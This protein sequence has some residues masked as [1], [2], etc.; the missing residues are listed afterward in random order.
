MPREAE[1]SPLRDIHKAFKGCFE[2]PT[3]DVCQVLLLMR[4]AAFML[5]AVVSY[6]VHGMAKSCGHAVVA[7]NRRHRPRLLFGLAATRPDEAVRDS[8]VQC[9]RGAVPVRS[10][11]KS[12]GARPVQSRKSTFTPGF[13]MLASSS[14]SQLVSLT[15]PCEPAL[16]IRLGCGVP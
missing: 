13:T 6:D 1:V 5:I 9:G 10:R 15:H 2:I 11:L 16:S 12:I 14:T 3:S 8:V 4:T 7:F